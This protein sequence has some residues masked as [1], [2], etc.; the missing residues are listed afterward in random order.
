MTQAGYQ[1]D[2]YFQ[3]GNKTKA[4][5]HDIH[6]KLAPK[7]EENKCKKTS[8]KFWNIRKEIYIQI[9]QNKFIDIKKF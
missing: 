6:S 1:T 9:L 2:F 4:L 7:M 8:I 5:Y 3:L